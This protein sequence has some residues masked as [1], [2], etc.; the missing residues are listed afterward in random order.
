MPDATEG[1]RVIGRRVTER[2][3]LRW[4]L[5]LISG[6]IIG[7][8]IFFPR[9]YPA[10]AKLLPQDTS[11]A[12]LGQILNSLGGQLSSFA[13]LLSGGRP[14]ADLYLVIGKSDIVRQDVINAERLVGDGRRYANVDD[15]KIDLGKKVDVRLLLGGVLEIEATTRDAAESQKLVAA[16]VK[17]IS[18]R[19]GALGRQTISRKGQIVDQR[20]RDAQI[21]VSQTENA[22]NAFRRANRLP[23]PEAQLSSE[24]QLRA[25]LQ[26]RLQAKLVEL[27]T[28]QEFAGPDNPQ[29][30]AVQAEVASLRTQIAQAGQANMGAAGPSLA[31]LS[32]IQSR[33]LNLF[34]DYR[35]AQA[36]YDVYARASEQVA[37]ENLVAESATYIQVVEPP[38]LDPE[39]HVNLAAVGALAALALFI[40]FIE[41]YVPL[42]G[43][44]WPD[45]VGRTDP[46]VAAR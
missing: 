37:V 12:G 30:R 32:E 40:L 22:L 35:F 31:G 43:L 6:L 8:L 45:L 5:Y 24:L 16:Y 34:R 46:D 41:I 42:T 7:V 29:L 26:A 3:R 27:Q 17:A 10:R 19:I 39:R 15:A 28:T 1:E 13:N 11:S 21:R 36:L 25:G 4:A 20:F 23:A 44:R 9:P 2:S 14:P 18:A 38:H 33:Y